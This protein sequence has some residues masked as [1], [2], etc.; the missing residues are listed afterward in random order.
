MGEPV[1][2]MRHIVH[3]ISGIQG[4]GTVFDAEARQTRKPRAANENG[5]TG[6]AAAQVVQ[7]GYRTTIGGCQGAERPGLYLIPSVGMALC[8]NALNLSSTGEGGRQCYE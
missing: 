6:Q 7:H 3:T 4:S 1:S 5:V 8:G 2:Q